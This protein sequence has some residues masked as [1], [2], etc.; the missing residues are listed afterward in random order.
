MLFICFFRWK[1]HILESLVAHYVQLIKITHLFRGTCCLLPCQ[2]N[3][4]EVFGGLQRIITDRHALWLNTDCGC[5]EWFK[6]SDLR[7]SCHCVSIVI[8][9]VADI[10]TLMVTHRD[11]DQ[12]QYCFANKR[13]ETN[14]SLCVWLYSKSL[15]IFNFV[16]INPPTLFFYHFNSEEGGSKFLY[17][18]GDFD[19]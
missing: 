15:T 16:I 6:H 10:G 3:W 5:L 12:D 7:C 11:T 8:L 18:V 2:S 13:E 4:N 17:S 9:N 14:Y 1:R 19:I